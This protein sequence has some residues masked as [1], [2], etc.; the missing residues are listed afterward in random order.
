M[1]S[2]V[3]KVSS[4]TGTQIKPGTIYVIGRV[5]SVRRFDGRTY[6]RLVMPALDQYSS[7]STI[8]FES[9]S[10]VGEVGE[11][12]KVTLSL[13]GYRNDYKSV[14]KETGELRTIRS[15]RITLKLVE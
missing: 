14:D 6:T 1:S 12:I 5:D 7:P 11:D 13:A 4:L 8:E 10:R 3:D 2:T 15:A 9:P